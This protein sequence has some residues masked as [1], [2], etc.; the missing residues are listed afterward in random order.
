MP[1]PSPSPQEARGSIKEVLLGFLRL[2]CTS[3]GGPVAHLGYFQKEIV[4][5]R[6]WRS[7]ERLAELSRFVPCKRLVTLRWR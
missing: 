7:D 3:F 6:R 1:N 5:R 2:G 4:E